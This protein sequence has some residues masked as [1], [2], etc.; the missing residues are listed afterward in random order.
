MKPGKEADS[1]QKVGVEGQCGGW[2]A[3]RWGSLSGVEFMKPFIPHIL[4]QEPLWI[5]LDV[6]GYGRRGKEATGGAGWG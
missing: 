3:L 1:V 6:C 5:D 4:L 2:G